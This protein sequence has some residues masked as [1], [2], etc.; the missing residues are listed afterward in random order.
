MSISVTER[1]GVWRV[2]RA[3]SR[4]CGSLRVNLLLVHAVERLRR[5]NIIAIANRADVTSGRKNLMDMLRRM[6]LPQ[7]AIVVG[8]L[9]RQTP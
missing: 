5:S 8:G 4:N 2:R 9:M 6:W 1:G 7:M 3:A